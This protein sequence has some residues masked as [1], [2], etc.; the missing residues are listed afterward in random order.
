MFPSGVESKVEQYLNTNC[1]Q[2][3]A[4][5]HSNASS[6]SATASAAGIERLFRAT[7]PASQAS[8]AGFVGTPRNCTVESPPLASVFAMSLAPVKSSAITPRSTRYLLASDRPFPKLLP[9]LLEKP[10]QHHA[11]DLV[12]AVDEARLAGVAIDPF[13]HRVLRVAAGTVDLDADVGGL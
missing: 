9:L 7:T 8:G 4:R 6:E 3:C 11:V 5:S 1:R 2:P 13:E 10:V 12:G